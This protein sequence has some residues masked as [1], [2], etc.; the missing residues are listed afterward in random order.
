MNVTRRDFL[1]LSGAA[2]SL[3]L[4]FPENLLAGEKKVPVLMYHDISDWFKDDYTIS[5]SQFASHMEWLYSNGYQ[6]LPV[7]ELADVTWDDNKRVVIITFDDG[8]ESF[9]EYAFPLLKGYGFKATINVI[10]KYVGT[11]IDFDRNRPVLSWDEYRYLIKSGVVDVGCHSY[12]LHMWRN[13]VGG[14]KAFS[15]KE[16][17]KDLQL[18]QEVLKKET[19]NTAN[20]LA[21]SYGIYDKESI[22]IAKQAGF[23][24][25]LTSN[26]GYLV[27]HSSLQEIPR[28]N[29]NDTIDLDA[30][31]KIMGESV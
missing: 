22:E 9:M 10:G 26:D 5:P 21:W 27:Q 3:L 8:Y 13:G 14:V 20:I 2:I 15:R 28:K 25:I 7:K 17:E 30:F 12:D 16:I 19:G 6:T 11:F 29:I 1:K 18:F 4:S 31:K 24:Y 23:Y